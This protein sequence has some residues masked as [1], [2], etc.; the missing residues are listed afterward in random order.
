MNMG[1]NPKK[2]VTVTSEVEGMSRGWKTRKEGKR[3]GRWEAES[4]DEGTGE[5]VTR[6]RGTHLTF[7]VAKLVS[8]MNRILQ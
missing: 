6:W 3:G 5:G 4:G 2:R 1:R 7:G 8:K